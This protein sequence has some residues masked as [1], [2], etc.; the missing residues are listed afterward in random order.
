MATRTLNVHSSDFCRLTAR[1]EVI[2]LL[3][4]AYKYLFPRASFR[5]IAEYLDISKDNAR[6][7][8][9]GVHCLNESSNGRVYQRMRLGSHTPYEMNKQ[10]AIKLLSEIDTYKA[11]YNF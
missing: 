4:N 5:D 6:R 9:Y 1:A 7:Y 8:Y 11:Q 2:M 10:L 3:A